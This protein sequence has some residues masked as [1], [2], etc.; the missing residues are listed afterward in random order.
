MSAD[1]RGAI[2]WFE[3]GGQ[4]TKGGGLAGAVRSEK[5]VNFAGMA[6]EAHMVNGANDTALL[7][8]EVLAQSTS[9]N[10]EIV[11]TDRYEGFGGNRA[12]LCYVNESRKITPSG[13]FLAS[14]LHWTGEKIAFAGRCDASNRVASS[15]L[16]GQMARE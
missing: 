1:N 15:L 6:R 5:A 11:L 4:Q 2:G 16:Q 12:C 13:R 3:D 9:F 14:A 8:L 7:V 10:H